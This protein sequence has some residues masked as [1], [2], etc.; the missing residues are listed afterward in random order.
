MDVRERP[1]S[2]TPFFSNI[3]NSAEGE[4]ALSA[5][6]KY[7]SVA[8]NE[9]TRCLWRSQNQTFSPRNFHRYDSNVAM[10]KSWT[11]IQSY[12][13]DDDIEQFLSYIRAYFHIS[14]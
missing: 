4:V 11:G 14:V 13:N 5:F 3:L 12:S 2:A 1:I 6:S 7:Q 9:L 8:Q 10:P